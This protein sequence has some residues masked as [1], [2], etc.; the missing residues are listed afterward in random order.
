LGVGFRAW[1]NDPDG[2][3]QTMVF[4]TLTLAQ[5][6]NALAIR[7][8]RDSLFRIGLLSNPS[9]L[10][11]VLL[12]FVLQL[13]VIYLPFL[14]QAFNTKALSAGELA[15]SLVMSTV[16]FWSVEIGKWLSRRRKL[17]KS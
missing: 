14:Q 5:M 1:S 7:S 11:A 8:S 6:G 12:T 17:S 10:G 4:T 3:W 13:A 15:I 9:M 2:A 16:V